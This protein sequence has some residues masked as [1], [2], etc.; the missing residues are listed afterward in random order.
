MPRAFIKPNLLTTSLIAFRARK[1][2]PLKPKGA[3][4]RFTSGL[5]GG[6]VA[7][8]AASRFWQGPVRFGFW[9]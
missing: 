1:T 8:E 3:A 9:N 7:A 4:P 5:F 2:A 6:I